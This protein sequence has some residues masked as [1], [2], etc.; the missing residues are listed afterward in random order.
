MPLIRSDD[1]SRTSKLFLEEA[2]IHRAATQYSSL[3]LKLHGHS[4]YIKIHALVFFS[5]FPWLTDNLVEDI[6]LITENNEI[7]IQCLE[8]LA[9][10]LHFGETGCLNEKQ[11]NNAQKLCKIF[12]MSM[13]TEE[14][15]SKS[16]DLSRDD[17]IDHNEISS[18]DA[19]NNDN[20]EEGNTDKSKPKVKT[21]KRRVFTANLSSS[22]L[23]C[24]V[25]NR[26][27]SA[28]YKLRIHRFIHS[29]TP[30]F[31]CSQCGR[32]FNNKYK[33]RGH[34]KRHCSSAD[35]DHKSEVKPGWPYSERLEKRISC[36]KCHA[37]F[38]TKKA[39]REH[40]QAAHPFAATCSLCQKSFRGLKGL[41]SHQ[42]NVDC[43]KS[44][45]PKAEKTSNFKCDKC[46]VI[47]TSRKSLKVH[48]KTLHLAEGEDALPFHCG[49]CQKSFLKHSYF[50]EHQNR[51]HADVKPFPCMYCPKRCATKQDLDRHLTSH[52][53][54]I[55]QYGFFCGEKPFF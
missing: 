11:F 6:L 53:C 4:D 33:M 32:G 25:C 15:S 22:D 48:A 52:R 13:S 35:A 23:T 24:S 37:L 51:F 55:L 39:R 49:V 34:E 16:H 54:I 12:G 5:A 40:I 36:E 20:V 50:E 42:Q 44:K 26:T 30:P 14:T 46:P 47:C 8:I 21:V 27:F 10:I 19:I 17:I 1:W 28:M 31:V 45:R 38:D 2:F 43:Q 9:K 41:K 18:D 29:K 7:D 3:T